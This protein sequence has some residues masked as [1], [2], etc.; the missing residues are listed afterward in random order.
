M[1]P[2]LVGILLV[3]GYYCLQ[4]Y[5]A[6]DA[7]EE[8][9]DGRLSSGELKMA[10]DIRSRLGNGSAWKR[11]H[12]DLYLCTAYLDDRTRPA[13]VRFVGVAN[14]SGHGHSARRRFYPSFECVFA[15]R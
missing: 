8:F 7:S 3:L 1:H 4:E 10:S 12:Q 2:T 11:T 9:K 14:A 13:L 6:S 5:V 15:Y